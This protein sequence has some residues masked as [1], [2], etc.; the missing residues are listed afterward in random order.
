M[1][2]AM[3]TQAGLPLVAGRWALDPDHSFVG[4]AV[5]HLGFAAT[6]EIRRSD[7]GIGECIRAAFVGDVIEVELDLQL[8]EPTAG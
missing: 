3:T 1:L 7:F 6:G 4:F 5:R 2:F 8:L